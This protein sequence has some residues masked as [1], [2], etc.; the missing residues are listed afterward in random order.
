M[1]QL[2]RH[3]RQILLWPLQLMPIREGSQIQ[4][5]WEL[6]QQCQGEHAWREFEE[7]FGCSPEEFQAI[8]SFYARFDQVPDSQV[9]E[10]LHSRIPSLVE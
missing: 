6:L 2:V 3:Y 8:G 10:I 4:E 9:I 5:P 7:D 1:A